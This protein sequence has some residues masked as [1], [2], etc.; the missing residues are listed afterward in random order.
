ME[1]KMNLSLPM[2]LLLG[3]GAASVAHAQQAVD[4]IVLSDKNKD[5][6][7]R[8]M[9]MVAGDGELCIVGHYYDTDGPKSYAR[10]VM[11]DLRKNKISWQHTIAAPEDNHGSKFVACR[12]KG[13]AVYA[14]ANVD[15][16]QA[17][18]M[19]FS[20]AYVYKFDRNGKQLGYKPVPVPGSDAWAYT[21]DAGDD[22]LKVLGLMRERDEKNEYYSIFVAKFDEKILFEKPVIYKSGAYSPGSAVKV[23]GKD[24]YFAGNFTAYKMPIDDVPAD[25]ANSKVRLGGAYAWSVR[26]QHTKPGNIASVISDAGTIHA[27]GFKA[28]DSSAS[29]FT[30]VDRS[31]KVISDVEYKSEFCKTS[32]LTVDGNMLYM[33]REACNANNKKPALVSFN[34]D[35][36]K[37]T[38]IKEISG[39]PLFVFAK[40][41]RIYLVSKEK[42]GSVVLRN[43]SA[44]ELK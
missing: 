7:V 35:Q 28:Y 39:T 14:T 9:E 33:I 16:S 42:D 8:T 22:E 10:I 27:V 12:V 17:E 19:N 6:G 29:Y 38:R 31:G 32:S 40:S 11:V 21:T 25:Y 30:A 1:L 41:D 26:P 4:K 2:A 23:S 44:R 36:A 20:T 18:S 13:D 24:A 5:M 43:S 34:V 3:L 15:S 37:E